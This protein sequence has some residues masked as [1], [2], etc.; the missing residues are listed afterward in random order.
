MVSVTVEEGGFKVFNLG[1][2]C[3]NNTCDNNSVYR[4]TD[5]E[6]FSMKHI[7]YGTDIIAHIGNLRFKEHKT[8]S[9]I[10]TILSEKQVKISKRQVQ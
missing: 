9:E 6:Q 7:T 5:A 1:Y 8:R 4:S 2:R 10:T 3:E